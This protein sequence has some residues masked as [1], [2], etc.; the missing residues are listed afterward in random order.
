M[1]LPTHTQPTEGNLQVLEFVRRRVF[2]A[3]RPPTRAE[4]ADEFGFSRPTAE[5]HLKSLE[6]CRLVRLC[7]AHRGIFLVGTTRRPEA[8]T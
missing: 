3:G 2:S 7:R 4:I 5:Y 1:R 8:R 6:R